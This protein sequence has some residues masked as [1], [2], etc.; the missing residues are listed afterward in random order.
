MACRCLFLPGTPDLWMRL[1][2]LQSSTQKGMKWGALTLLEI[3]HS[4]GCYLKFAVLLVQKVCSPRL[5]NT[6]ETLRLYVLEAYTGQARLIRT[7]LIRK[8]HLIRSFFEI[9]ARFLIISCLKCT[10]NS[11]TVNWKFHQFEGN[12]TVS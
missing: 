9:F 3:S 5:P 10:V 8:F 2:W 1:G 6:K 11:N 7:R 4:R 12:L